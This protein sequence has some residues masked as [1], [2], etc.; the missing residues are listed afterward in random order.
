MTGSER[1]IVVDLRL[2]VPADRRT[3][4]K[5]AS[6]AN[7][8]LCRQVGEPHV[9]RRE[10][11]GLRDFEQRSRDSSSIAMKVTTTTGT[12]R[13]VSNSSWN[14]TKRALQAAQHLAHVLAHRQLLARDPVVL[15]ELG[16]LEDVGPGLAQVARFTSGKAR[17]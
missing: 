6:N 12:P 8:R 13:V 1:G 11:L 5:R 14:S 10:G 4:V 9:D 16:A 2:P 3:E 17:T 15:H 7:G